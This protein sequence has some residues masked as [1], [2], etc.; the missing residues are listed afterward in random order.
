MNENLQLKPHI[1]IPE[2]KKK[3]KKKQET[4]PSSHYHFSAMN[5][6]KF[7]LGYLFLRFQYI[8]VYV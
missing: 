4:Q 5:L 8:D 1:Y 6:I 2:Q 3:K 7:T